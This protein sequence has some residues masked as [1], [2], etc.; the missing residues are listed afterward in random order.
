MMNHGTTGDRTNLAT[1]EIGKIAR[2]EK[3]EKTVMFS[4]MA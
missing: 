2:F 3:V 4:K 1:G